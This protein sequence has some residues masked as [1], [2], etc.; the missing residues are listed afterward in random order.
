[1]DFIK[2]K[3]GFFFCFKEHHQASEK[4][5]HK[6]FANNISHAE[7]VSRIYGRFTIEQ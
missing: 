2:I 1:M 7:L 6:I 3:K 4:T 5:N